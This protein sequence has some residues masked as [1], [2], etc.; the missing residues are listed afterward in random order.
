MRAANLVI[1][2]SIGAAVAILATCAA[3]VAVGSPRAT[4]AEVL[5][6]D[7]ESYPLGLLGAPWIVTVNTGATS[8]STAAVVSTPDHGKALRL[9]GNKLTPDFLIASLGLSSSVPE[10]RVEVDVKP[11]PGASFIW[12]LHGAGPSI[13][14]RRIRLQ[15]APGGTGLAAQT[16]PSGTTACGAV[17]SNAW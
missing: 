15:R 2:A 10:I 6:V 5:N 12:S 16:S 4:A 9:H 13:G 1:R 7:F 17:A 14:S 11:D 8:A 3:A